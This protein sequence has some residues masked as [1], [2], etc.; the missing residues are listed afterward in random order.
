MERAEPAGPQFNVSLVPKAE[1]LRLTSVTRLFLQQVGITFAVVAVLIAAGAVLV[2][3]VQGEAYTRFTV[4]GFVA[5]CFF[6][7]IVF[8][9]ANTLFACRTEVV[10]RHDAMRVRNDSGAKRPLAN[11]VR[12][13]IPMGIVMATL[14]TVLVGAYVYGTG[15]MP[16]PLGTALLSLLFVVPYAAIA[17]RH[18]VRDI[19]GLAAAGPNSAGKPAFKL[20]HVTVNYVLPN[21][22]LQAIIN[23]PLA[24]R[25]FSY[26]AGHAGS[27]TVP[28][29]ALVPD[30]AITFIFVC[31]FTFL[32]VTA[33][34]V[35]DLYLGI[36]VYRGKRHAISGLRYS[37]LI[38]LMGIALGAAVAAAGAWWGIALVSFAQAMAL[39]LLLVVFSVALACGLGVA[40]TGKKFNATVAK[41]R[42]AE[43]QLA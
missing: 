8:L 35:S 10:R 34:A 12:R 1:N 23:T 43:V 16:S 38:V 31:G 14:C 17:G 13:T 28:V 30:F 32:T 39:K 33:H 24:W 15:W 26:S 29:S 9:P 19:E 3:K 22:V 27:G 37:G 2:F 5:T 11:P 4:V 40:W 41:A 20:W 42:P 36:M 7:F 6:A 25:G 21:L 18:V